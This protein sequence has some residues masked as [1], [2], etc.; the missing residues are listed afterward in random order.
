M[1]FRAFSMAYLLVNNRSILTTYKF[2]I[3][4]NICQN[5]STY[6]LIAIEK[7]YCS[8]KDK[9]LKWDTI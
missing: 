1:V 5:K 8:K 4:M 9:N 2:P 6:S 7:E 3:S